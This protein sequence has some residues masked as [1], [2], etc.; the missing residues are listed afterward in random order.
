MVVI[1]LDWLHTRWLAWYADR[2]PPKPSQLVKL[3][4]AE[5]WVSQEA[6]ARLFPGTTL[7]AG[8]NTFTLSNGTI[9]HLLE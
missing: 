2:L 8:V 4:P 1:L 3:S 9:V 7:P 5:Y 6:F